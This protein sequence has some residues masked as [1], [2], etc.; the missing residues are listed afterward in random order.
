MTTLGPGSG[1]TPGEPEGAPG[2]P[3]EVWQKF[4]ADSED[5]IRGSA[6]REP[7]ARERV[8]GWFPGPPETAGAKRR[9][10][11]PYDD[12]GN[13]VAGAVGDLWQPEEPRGGPI[14]R[15]LDR[16]A[17]LRRVG[18]A[19]GTAAAVA[20]ALAAWSWLTAGSG[21]PGSGPGSATVQQLEDAPEELPTATARPLGVPAGG[22]G[23]ARPAGPDGRCAPSASWSPPPRQPEPWSCG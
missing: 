15:N 16:S 18:R 4:L 23:E 5:A 10:G 9:A 8:P 19:A 20:L 7:S 14:W 13:A 1:D 17:R 21:V 2:V 12:R 3:E 22:A 6:P 11:R